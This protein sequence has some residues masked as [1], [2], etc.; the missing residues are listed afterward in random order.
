MK[1]DLEFLSLFI[2][3]KIHPYQ[4]ET[5]T[6]FL[7]VWKKYEFS[8]MKH[9]VRRSQLQIIIP[10][11][12]CFT[13]PRSRHRTLTHISKETKN[14]KSRLGIVTQEWKKS[15]LRKPLYILIATSRKILEPFSSHYTYHEIKPLDLVYFDEHAK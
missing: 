3:Y 2:V 11:P 10:S 12:S 4:L 7:N 13:Y 14:Y 9:Y 6:K 5:Y 15:H 1:T 8:K